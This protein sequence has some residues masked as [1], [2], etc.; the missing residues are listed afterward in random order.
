LLGRLISCYDRVLVLFTIHSV[1]MFLCLSVTTTSLSMR[2]LLYK[3]AI[4]KTCARDHIGYLLSHGHIM[5]NGG[6]ALKEKMR[7]RSVEGQVMLNTYY[8]NS[9]I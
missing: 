8:I 1:W 9:F 7:E 5:C 4:A 2:E 6:D 3:E